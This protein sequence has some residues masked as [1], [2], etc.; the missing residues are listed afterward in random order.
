[1]KY[2]YGFLLGDELLHVGRIGEG[3]HQLLP[4][5]CFKLGTPPWAWTTCS[6]TTLIHMVLKPRDFQGVS[7]TLPYVR[8]I[9]DMAVPVVIITTTVGDS[10]FKEY[11]PVTMPKLLADI[12]DLLP[13]GG[14]I[15]DTSIVTG[16]CTRTIHLYHCPVQR[17]GTLYASRMSIGGRYFDIVDGKPVVYSVCL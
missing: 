17:I 4:G 6:P 14:F 16:Y 15:V 12:S 10:L 9:P 3:D 7:T 8:N 1:M 11:R 5:D 2:K 13:N